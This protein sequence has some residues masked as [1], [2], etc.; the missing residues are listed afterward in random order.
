MRTAG[1]RLTES[2][3]V[4]FF[5][6][7]LC[8]ELLSGSTNTGFLFKIYGRL[9]TDGRGRGLIRSY[10]GSIGPITEGRYIT[11][12]RCISRLPI[13]EGRGKASP[14]MEGRGNILGSIIEALVMSI[15][16]PGRRALSDFIL[17]ST[18]EGRALDRI[19]GSLPSRTSLIF[20]LRSLIYSRNLAFSRS[21]FFSSSKSP[22]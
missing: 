19:W 12:P 7:Y 14:S 11:L 17:G 1:P 8:L 5:Y 9:S 4:C 16:R 2:R 20:W 15:S 21:S 18:G 3:A 10:E 6:R 22:T 13:T